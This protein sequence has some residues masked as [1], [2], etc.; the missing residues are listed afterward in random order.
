MGTSERKQ[1]ERARREQEIVAK[2]KE[3]FL[4]KG[5]E[6]TTVDE[7]ADALEISKGVIY[8]HFT[9]KEE[10]YFRILREGHEIM[11]NC[12]EQA[13]ATQKV[14]LAKF[15]AIG[16]AYGRFWNDYPDYRRIMSQTVTHSK[17]VEPGLE[18]KQAEEIDRRIEQIDVSTIQLGIADGS[19]RPDINPTVAAFIISHSTHGVLQALE[20]NECHLNEMKIKPEDVMITA[21][22]LLGRSISNLPEE[23]LSQF[24]SIVSGR[25]NGTKIRKKSNMRVKT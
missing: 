23:K 2:A 20:D 13:V 25:E 11:L 22:E 6:A 3:L 7:I 18:R 21:I 8:A 24:S 16:M 14:G 5:Y 15:G 12:F 10:I 4:A 17:T 9:G 1:R 19:I